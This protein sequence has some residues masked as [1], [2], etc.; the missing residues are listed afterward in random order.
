MIKNKFFAVFII[1][2][3]LLTITVFAPGCKKVEGYADPIIENILIAMNET[4]FEK[5]S[6]DFDENLK[7]EIS[8]ASFPNLLAEVNGKAG[9]YIKDSKKMVGVKTID[10]RTAVFY[11]ADFEGIQEVS[12]TVVFQ[13]INNK[14]RVVGFWFE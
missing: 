14:P 7:G 13:Q 8:I 12:I 4:D 3:V 9:Y 10:N 1:I 5:F 2:A 11:S 6:K